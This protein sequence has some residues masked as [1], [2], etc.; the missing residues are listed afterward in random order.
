M[1]NFPRYYVLINGIKY[2]WVRTR[3]SQ[4]DIRF[5]NEVPRKDVVGS[6]HRRSFPKRFPRDISAGQKLRKVMSAN[7]ERESFADYKLDYP[8]RTSIP[9]L[10]PSPS[11]RRSKG[12]SLIKRRWN[13]CDQSSCSCNKNKKNKN[14]FS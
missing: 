1:R 5:R 14:I 9:Y 7:N 11:V 8:T 10:S 2:I 3:K 6:A 13:A 12:V 4:S